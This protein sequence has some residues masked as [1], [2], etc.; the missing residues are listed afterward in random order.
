MDLIGEFDLCFTHNEGINWVKQSG[1]SLF[2]RGPEPG[3]VLTVRLLVV[4]WVFLFSERDDDPLTSNALGTHTLKTPLA[5]R[6]QADPSIVPADTNV[7]ILFG[8][9][10][11]ME[12]ATGFPDDRIRISVRIVRALIMEMKMGLGAD[13]L[14]QMV[15][16]FRQPGCPPPSLNI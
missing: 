1:A 15:H 7:Q 4:V 5:L 14:P 9:P 6:C 11:V 16:L 12:Q 10:W 8:G 3:S 13:A 2:V